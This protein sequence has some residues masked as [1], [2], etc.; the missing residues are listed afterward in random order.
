MA[1]EKQPSTS[2]NKGTKLPKNTT[3]EE[4]ATQIARD[5]SKAGTGKGLEK[6]LVG[7][8]VGKSIN[9]V[10]VKKNRVGKTARGV[11]R[12]KPDKGT[13]AASDRPLMAQA[14]ADTDLTP[15]ETNLSGKKVE[16]TKSATEKRS[17]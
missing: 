17:A 5:I 6:E 9:K 1:E 3:A 2:T 13:T 16:K 12:Y 15:G 8:I 10:I 14:F 4:L 11:V 7:K